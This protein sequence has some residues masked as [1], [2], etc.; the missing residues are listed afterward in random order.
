MESQ[1]FFR[2]VQGSRLHVEQLIPPEKKGGE[3]LVFLH[4]ALGSIPQWK[5]FPALLAGRCG[6]EAIIYERQGHGHSSPLNARRTAGYLQREA[7]DYL[8]QLLEQLQVERPVLF[9]HSD[10]GTIALLYAAHFRPAAIITEAAH[11]FV[12]AVTLAGIRQAVA[13]R[14]RLMHR[15]QRY[16]GKQAEVLFEAWA[17]TWLDP[18]FHEWDITAELAG[19]RCPALIIQGENDEYGT[20]RQVEAIARGIGNKAIALLIPE[21]SHT[22]H[23]EKTTLVLDATARFLA[24][25]ETRSN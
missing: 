2:T 17:D 4:D 9:G 13:K 15:L 21:C 6:L 1:H 20:R 11:V 16:H 18:S 23:R 14:E 25:I 24:E 8:P 5:D 12:E 19:I 7:F 10:G 22:P 3:V